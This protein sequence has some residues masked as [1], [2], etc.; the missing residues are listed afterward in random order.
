MDDKKY[1]HVRAKTKAKKE[2]VKLKKG[3]YFI[4]VKEKAERGKANAKIL[5]LLANKLQCN[6]KNLR[7]IKGGTK[8]SK[9]YLLVNK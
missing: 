2:E 1:I 5:Q 4:S 6:P 9:T 8:T 3:K 7:M